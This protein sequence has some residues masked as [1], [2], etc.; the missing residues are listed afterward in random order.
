[1]P[2]CLPIPVGFHFSHPPPLQSDGQHLRLMMM[3]MM[4]TLTMVVVVIIIIHIFVIMKP[5]LQVLV[6]PSYANS[7]R[8]CLAQS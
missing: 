2:P 4:M 3:I 7:E 8:A 6:I 1:M 5:L